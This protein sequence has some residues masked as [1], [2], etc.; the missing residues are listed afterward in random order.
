MRAILHL[1]LESGVPFSLGCLGAR[2]ML[3]FLVYTY[4]SVLGPCVNAALLEPSPIGV[5]PQSPL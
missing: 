4:A 3:R 2:A 1:V 5:T